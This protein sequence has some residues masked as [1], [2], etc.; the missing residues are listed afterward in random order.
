MPGFVTKQGL[1]RCHPDRRVM[2]RVVPKLG[3]WD[4]KAPASR[5]YVRVATKVSFQALVDPLR[6]TVYLRMVGRAQPQLCSSILEEFLLEMAGENWVAVR[7]NGS[8]QPVQL[9]DLV[10][11]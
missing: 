10:Y 4:P 5:T 1:E 6:L 8:G 2:G 11:V 7:D 3:K 9:V